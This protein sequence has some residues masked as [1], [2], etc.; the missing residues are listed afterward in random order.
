M[1]SDPE[2]APPSDPASPTRTRRPWW[3]PFFLGAIPDVDAKSLTL[4]GTVGLAVFFEAYDLSLLTSAL[5]FIA[6]DLEI[7]EETLGLWTGLIRL[8]GLPAFALLPFADRFGRRKVCLLYT[9][10]SPR[11]S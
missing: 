10:P 7:T 6:A 9:S 1:S 11:D 2:Q 4:L 3:I 5:S 8:G